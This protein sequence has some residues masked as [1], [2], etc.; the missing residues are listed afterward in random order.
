MFVNRLRE[1]A[2]LERRYESDQAELIV[3][4]SLRFHG[5]ADR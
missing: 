1:L 3:L 4:L 5:A 2:F